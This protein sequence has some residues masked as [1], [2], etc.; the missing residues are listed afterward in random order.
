MDECSSQRIKGAMRKTEVNTADS[1][2]PLLP[3]L[4]IAFK[5]RVGAQ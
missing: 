1:R 5:V 3:N 4:I 2:L